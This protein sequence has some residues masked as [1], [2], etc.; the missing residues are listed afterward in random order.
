MT[1]A[2]RTLLKR[3]ISEI[4]RRRHKLDRRISYQRSGPNAPKGFGRRGA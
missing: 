4:Q 2:Q 1:A 3:E